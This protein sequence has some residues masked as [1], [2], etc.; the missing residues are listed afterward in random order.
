V[1]GKRSIARRHFL[2]LVAGG[3]AAAF[4][5]PAGAASGRSGSRPNFLI[6]YTDD[7]G[8]GDLSC[9]G[10]KDIRTP[11]MDAL[12]ASGVRFTSW[13]SNAPVC[14]ASR[15]SLLTGRY[16][17]RAGAPGIFRSSRTAPGMPTTEVTLAEALKELGY[18]TG[19]VGKWHL[20]QTAE[21]RPN[22]QGFDYFFGFLSGCIDYYS[23]I[24]YWDQGRGRVPFHDLWRNDREVWENGR[25]FTKLVTRE[26]RRFIADNRSR[27]FFLYVAYN[28]PHYP[29]HAPREYFGR[30]SYIKDPQRRTQAAMVATVDDSI[31]EIMEELRRNGLVERTVIFFQSDNGPSAEPRNLLDDSRQPY[32]GGSAGPFRGRKGGLFEGGIRMP[33]ILSWPGTIPAGRVVDEV[34]IAMDIF[35]TFIKIAGGSVPKDRAIDGKDIFAMAARGAPSPHDAVFW[36]N[37][38]QR[39]VRRGKWKLILN[40]KL[41]FRQKAKDKVFLADLEKDPGESV[42]LS[43][44]YPQVVKELRNLIECWDKDVAAKKR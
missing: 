13:Y 19:I 1:Q 29:M 35:P 42:N 12:A 30:F 24:F 14:S 34:G 26:A 17:R 32:H 28:A 41:S 36:A 18:R 33:A 10:A 25:Y 16:P 9:Y 8:W 31:G 22:A 43:E 15:A 6:F 20:G 5:G 7:Q 21:C 40:G 44:K 4:L 27:P 23:H 39:A 2:R 37:G 3:T 38:A 11:N